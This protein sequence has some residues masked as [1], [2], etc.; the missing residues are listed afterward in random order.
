MNPT[1]DALIELWKRIAKTVIACLICFA[2]GAVGG[3]V[4]HM[5]YTKDKPLEVGDGKIE[6][7]EKIKWMQT[8]NTGACCN[9][10]NLLLADYSDFLNSEP[11]IQK[12]TTDKIFFN[13]RK[14][15]YSLPYSMP[16][17]KPKWNLGLG[18]AYSG[19]LSLTAGVS[20]T[21]IHF[22]LV[23]MT[24]IGGQGQRDIAALIS[25]QGSF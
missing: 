14:S 13:I 7:V 24:G 20:F 17:E 10:Y 5:L 21:I 25:Y 9:D 2:L 16:G 3:W 4:G 6:Y 12:I 18:Y 15:Q 22:S 19:G 23:G 8:T 1:V 11:L